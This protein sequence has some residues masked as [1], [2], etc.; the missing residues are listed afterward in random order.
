MRMGP[1]EAAEATINVENVP[2][3]AVADLAGC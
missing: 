1:E 2:T 3:S